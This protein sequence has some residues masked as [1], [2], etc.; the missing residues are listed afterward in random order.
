MPN[1]DVRDTRRRWMRG[2][3]RVGNNTNY[4][5]IGTAGAITLAGTARPTKHIWISPGDFYT[6][7]ASVALTSLNSM[8]T[9]ALFSPSASTSDVTIYGQVPVPEDCDITAGLTPKVWWSRGANGASTAIADWEVDIDSVGNNEATS[10]AS[11]AD[12]TA[13]ASYSGDATNEITVS[14]LDTVGENSIAVGDLLSLE[15]R[16]EG[17]DGLTTAGCPYFLGLEIEY[18]VAAL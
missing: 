11:T 17:S 12:V 7:G 1:S 3:A 18:R 9:A 5:D 4:C 14:T 2:G 8:W 10:T 6:G 15:F 16:L 13:G